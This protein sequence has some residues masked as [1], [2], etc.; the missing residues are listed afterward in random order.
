MLSGTANEN[1]LDRVADDFAG[2]A[3]RPT[4]SRAIKTSTLPPIRI[5]TC[6][7]HRCFIAA[8]KRLTELVARHEQPLAVF[9]TRVVEVDLFFVW[10]I[11]LKPVLN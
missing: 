6:C 3:A 5:T 2:Y 9:G 8:S 11:I 7:V 10:P 4:N 1:T